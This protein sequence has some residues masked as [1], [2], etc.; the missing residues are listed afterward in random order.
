MA[1]FKNST[2]LNLFIWLNELD[3]FFMTLRIE[4]FS[5]RLKELNSFQYHSKQWT[6][7]STWLKELNFIELSLNELNLLFHDSK[8]WT[9]FFFFRDSMNWIFFCDPK[10]CTFFVVC[11]PEELKLFCWMWPKELSHCW[12]ILRIESF[13]KYDWEF[14][15]FWTFSYDSKNWTFFDMTRR[16]EPF[17]ECDSKNCNFL[18]KVS[19]RIDFS[20]RDSK[21]WI[22]F[23]MTQRI[24]I[25]SK[26]WTAFFNMTHRI[27]HLF[28]RIWRTELNIF[29]RIWRTELN[30]SSLLEYDSQK[31]F[32]NMTHRTEHLF[33]QMTQRI[34]PFF[35]ITQ[36]I[37]PFFQH[38]SKNWTLFSTWLTE[39][40]LFFLQLTQR[41]EHMT[42][43][44]VLI[45]FFQKYDPKVWIF[46]DMTQR[47]EHFWMWLKELN[48]FWTWLK[49]LNPLHKRTP[50]I[51]FF[52]FFY[53]FEPFANTTHRIEPFLN[54]MTHWD[55]TLLFNMSQR[56]WL[57]FRMT[58]R[59]SSFLQNVWLKEWID[60]SWKI[61]L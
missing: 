50:R 16:I 19:P 24:E 60:R 13:N 48:T 49:E 38:N 10:N 5:A 22:F 54:N 47:I 27:E 45:E 57:I 37:E 25:D 51:D 17:F 33:L 39:L 59:F 21:N 34:E 12:N 3:L 1:Y 42:W 4:P 29:S 35:N 14:N 43:L 41:I 32:L 9:F 23:N 20:E 2:L 11:D 6:F 18:Q 15:P 61:W 40:N 52:H 55:W 8:N 44:N 26:H 31:F 28:S 53:R 58:Q 30:I 36:R 46:S 7:F 56:K